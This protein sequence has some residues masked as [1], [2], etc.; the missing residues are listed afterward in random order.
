MEL[1]FISYLLPYLHVLLLLCD[2]THALQHLLCLIVLRTVLPPPEPHLPRQ[3]VSGAGSWTH[4]HTD[5]DLS[6]SK[7]HKLC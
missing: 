6:L 5:R 7:T 2:I 4:V 3:G 1:P